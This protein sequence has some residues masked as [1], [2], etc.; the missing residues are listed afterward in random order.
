MLTGTLINVAL[1]AVGTLCGLTVKRFLSERLKEALLSAVGLIV[2]FIGIGSAVSA[3]LTFTDGAFGTQYT[4]IMILSIVF[5]T[6]IGEAIGIEKL[7][8]RF[9]AFCQK[10]LVHGDAHSTFAEGMVT[11]SLIFVVGAMAV[12]GALDNGIRGNYDVLLA[13]SII[14]GI[15]SVVL[16]STLGIGVLFSA[17]AV[18][19][20]Q[21]A[22]SLLGVW[23][24]PYLTDAVIAQM[25]FTGAILIFAIGLKMLNIAK[26]R[27]GNMLPAI[28]MPILFDLFLR[29]FHLIAG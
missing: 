3:S 20:Y 10:K 8:D 25:S 2:L 13:K 12:V 19:V 26:I 1:I 5:G 28:F 16:A 21:G 14:D 7:L 18:F 23:I 17:V 27:V 22:I 24:E 11:A 15:T 9:G 6:V 29:V 4:L